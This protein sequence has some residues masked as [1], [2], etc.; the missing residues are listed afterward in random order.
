MYTFIDHSKVPNYV[1]EDRYRKIL[2]DAEDSKRLVVILRPTLF[3]YS[4]QE[5]TLGK[6]REYFTDHAITKLIGDGFIKFKDNEG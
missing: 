2:R 3:F 1:L 4:T 5:V 6:I